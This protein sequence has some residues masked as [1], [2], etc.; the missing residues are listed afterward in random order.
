LML[1]NHRTVVCFFLGDIRL[2]TAS[3]INLRDAFAFKAA[4]VTLYAS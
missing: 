4:F 1:T 3:S 2:G